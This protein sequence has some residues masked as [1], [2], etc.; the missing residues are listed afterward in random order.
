MQGFLTGGTCT[1]WG[2]ETSK[3][4]VRNEASE[5]WLFETPGQWPTN[6]FVCWHRKVVDHVSRNTAQSNLVQATMRGITGVCE[7]G[8][9]LFFF[10]D[11]PYTGRLAVK[12]GTLKRL[13]AR[14]QI[15][16]AHSLGNTGLGVQK[17]FTKF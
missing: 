11:Y 14:L 16:A 8:N 15:F 5:S 2:Y 10:G 6:F 9:D 17:H 1:P 3:Q 7:T 12:I 4:G 13:A